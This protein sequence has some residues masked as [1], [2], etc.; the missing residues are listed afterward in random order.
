MSRPTLR[1]IAGL[2]ARELAAARDLPRLLRSGLVDREYYAAQAGRAFGSDAAVAVHYLRVGRRAGL[3]PHPLYEPEWVTGRRPTGRAEPLLAAVRRGGVPD[4]GPLFDAAAYR[5]LTPAA[6]RHPGGPL[7]HF[8]ARAGPGSPLP[9]HEH[10]TWGDARAALLAEARAEARR[11]ALRRSRRTG[12][13]D[14]AA[15]RRLLAHATGPASP[16]SPSPA[17]PGTPPV[18]VVM[19]VRN[20]PDA[21]RAAVASVVAQTHR[22]WEL[23][24]VDDGSDDGTPAVLA[25]LA[26]ADE[27]VRVVTLPPSGVSAARNAGIAA[28]RAPR[29]AFL[30]SDNTWVPRFLEVILGAMDGT[31]ARAAHAVVDA[32]TPGPGRY[33]AFEGGLDELLVLNH[34]DLNTLVVD[35]DLLDAVGGFDPALRRWVDHDLAIRLARRTAI[36][37]VP[38][39][40]VHYDAQDDAGADDAGAGDAGAGDAGAGDAGAGGRITVT[41]TEHWQYAVLGKAHVDWAAAGERLAGRVPGRVTVSMP[42]YEDWTMTVTAVRAVLAAAT[43]DGDDVEVIVVDNGSRRAVASILA[44]AFLGEPR[45]RVLSQAR[46]LNFAIGSN[47]GAAEGTGEVV[48][49]LNNDTR[50]RPGWLA[51]L[52]AALRDPATLGAQPL[53]LYPDG[54]VQSAGTAFPGDGGLPAA[55]LAG[56]A[57]ADADGVA[58]IRLPAVT[59]AALAMRAG[60]V[61]ALRGFDPMYVNGFE[62]VDLCLRAVEAH[63]GGAFAVVT[64]AVVLHD[65]SRTPGRGRRIQ[66]NRRIFLDR[67]RDRLPGGDLGLLE[68]VGLRVAR[69]E[70]DPVGPGEVPVPRPV[71]ERVP[72]SPLR[73]AVQVPV[74]AAPAGDGD[75]RVA[76]AEALAAALRAL[77]QHV[78][79]DRAE[80]HGRPSAALDDVVVPW[81]RID[82]AG[83]RTP[84]ALAAE[85]VAEA[86]RDRDTPVANRR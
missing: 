47:L 22:G 43:G 46:N 86:A 28:G 52:V 75:P 9:G 64:D 84:A 67:W 44:A 23:V 66:E 56:H 7:G 35:R 31:G 8:A 74:T 57:A 21:V 39:V 20:R 63:P 48:A 72:G 80:A 82:A 55:L 50:V 3:S 26:A 59:A 53:L 68:R 15:E 51:P 61:V 19:P 60:D 16:A 29:V 30:D 73:W 62:D 6:A 42:T 69:F 65:E 76:R 4:P 33:L 36:P 34:V 83:D 27:R 49:F 81:S 1:R 32:G 45:V 2:G 18:T 38:F 77:G 17:L 78:A 24:V 11:R 14:A 71:L 41:E 12:E 10:L 40:G 13:W 58:P 5:R 37:L 85:L 70:A 79:V 54:T 25:E